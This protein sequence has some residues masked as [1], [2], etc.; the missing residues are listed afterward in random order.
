MA[1]VTD[2]AIAKRP[3]LDAHPSTSS[4]TSSG[5]SQHSGDTPISRTRV[6]S[7]ASNTSQWAAS[8]NQP[9]PSSQPLSLTKLT[10]TH[11]GRNGQ[12]SPN[13]SSPT[14]LPGHRESMFDGPLKPLP[15]REGQRDEAGL[16]LHQLP[17][18]T[19]S[20]DRRPSHPSPSV[21]DTVS[22]SLQHAQRTGKGNPPPLMTSESTA[23]TVMSS[24]SSGST[25]SSSY[26]T[27]RTPMEP[28]LDRALPIPSLFA[29]K[30]SSSYEN[31]LPPLRPPSLS[32]Q[33]S[34]L[35]AQHSPNSMLFPLI[36]FFP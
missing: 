16:S 2:L 7:S 20:G 22:G 30:S 6:D 17:R 9:S 4:G 11:V 5:A 13:T 35:T 31:Q 12:T 34:M 36:S 27:P 18:I 8:N 10:S 14:I 32:P 28:P 33:S 1:P 25:N 24:A 21:S 26:F 3:K 19:N 29:Q 23:G 15:W